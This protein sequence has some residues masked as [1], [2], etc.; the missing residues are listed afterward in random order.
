MRP[1]TRTHCNRKGD[2][3]SEA[4]C[5]P[6]RGPHTRGAAGGAAAGSGREEGGCRHPPYLVEFPAEILVKIIEYIPFKDHSKIRLVRSSKPNVMLSRCDGIL[7]GKL[8]WGRGTSSPF[9]P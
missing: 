9:P 5:P 3:E 2:C 8:V 7:I 1:H 4:R 6:P